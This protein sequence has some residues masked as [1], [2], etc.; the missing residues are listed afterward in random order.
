MRST[1]A[2]TRLSTIGC[3]CSAAFARAAAFLLV[4]AWSRSRSRTQTPCMSATSAAMPQGEP[5]STRTS[6]VQFGPRACC[7]RWTQA[8]SMIG[9][10]APTPTKTA[11]TAGGAQRNSLSGRASGSPLRRSDS[12]RATVRL[13]IWIGRSCDLR[14][15]ALAF[16]AIAP[17][18]TIATRAFGRAG[19]FGEA[20][21]RDG[22]DRNG[23]A[24]KARYLTDLASRR[25]VASRKAASMTFELCPLA[26]A[27]LQASR[28]WPRIWFSPSTI[29]SS[30]PATR[31]R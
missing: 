6:S 11:S 10:R 25:A 28:T 3:A 16:C 20:A 7:T 1:K 26:A 22:G 24:A 13:M 5:T 31:I 14:S 12:A 4:M 29:D 18:P 23:F 19:A 2:S 27:R 17:A 15:C 9:C 21:G 8:R 30:E